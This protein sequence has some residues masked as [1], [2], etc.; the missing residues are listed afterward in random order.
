MDTL[1]ALHSNTVCMFLLLLLVALIGEVS[2]LLG[3][4]YLTVTRWSHCSNSCVILQGA[5]FLKHN[6]GTLSSQASHS[7]M[8]TLY[9]SSSLSIRTTVT[10]LSVL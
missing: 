7:K 2:K 10:V 5:P 3:G 1:T 8:L 6:C 9:F 4:L